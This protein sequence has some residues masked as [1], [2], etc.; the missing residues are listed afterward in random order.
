MGT[1]GKLELMRRTYYRLKFSLKFLF[2][3]SL[4][5]EANVGGVSCWP[6]LAGQAVELW[7]CVWESRPSFLSTKSKSQRCYIQVTVWF[8]GFVPNI[9]FYNTVQNK[10]KNSEKVNGTPGFIDIR[11]L[12]QSSWKEISTSGM[13]GKGHFVQCRAGSNAA[14]KGAFQILERERR[15]PILS[16][17]DR[18][19]NN[20]VQ[21]RTFYWYRH[22]S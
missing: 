13:A 2:I 3:G 8:M 20:T 21:G 14:V 22:R 1:N 16:V 18:Q 5:A 17:L 9:A 6:L 19:V 7:V 12:L 15:L 11:K 4:P 10:I